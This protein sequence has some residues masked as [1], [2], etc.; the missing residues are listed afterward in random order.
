[1][2]IIAHVDMDAFYA[3]VEERHHPELRG[4]P[5]VVGAD[6]K[7]GMG[8]GVVTAA[9][10]AA[11][12]YG[13]RSALPISRAWR[14]AE[15][16]RRAGEPE[17]V[18][19]R[20]ERALYVDVSRRIMAIVARGADACEEASI[21][22]AYVDLSSLDD[23]ERAAAQARALKAEVLER[24][25]L[26]CS[27]GIG[28]NKL[29][30][31]IASDFR[32]PDGLTVVR[33]EEAQAFLDPLRIRVIPGIGPKTEVFL[34]GEGVRTVAALRGI[35]RA[36]LI[37][38]FGRWGAELYDK[39]R[40]ISDDPVSSEWEPRS[41]GEQETFAVDSLD[42]AFILGRARDLA[43]GVFRRFAAEGFQAFRTVTLTVRFTGFVTVS[44][45]H[46]VKATLTEEAQLQAAV[47]RL[48]EPFFDA[49][50]N[51][52]GKQIRI[53]GV[54]VEKLLRAPPVETSAPAL[55]ECSPQDWPGPARRSPS[56]RPADPTL[57]TSA[58]GP[59]PE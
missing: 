52:R 28:P 9:N 7:A 51:P 5:V 4:R 49:R 43:A 39:A 42:P 33:P 18:F 12:M 25:G 55:L 54:R 13:I 23:M 32:K 22:E 24:E 20:G 38:W 1:M 31:K 14:L 41:V 40:G 2:R 11:R 34:H 58:P 53:I 29:V 48:L 15:A 47:R 8:R 16:A 10:Y 30:A 3:A 19:V 57:G 37:E 44:R 45:S 17:T 21:D 36:R 35:E 50:E 6:P 56:A 59:V 46:T 26:T 27:I